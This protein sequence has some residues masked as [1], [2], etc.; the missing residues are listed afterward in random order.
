M[1]KAYRIIL[2]FALST[3]YCHITV[4]SE[5]FK[6]IPLGVRASLKRKFASHLKPFDGDGDR[7]AGKIVFIHWNGQKVS[8]LSFTFVQPDSIS[9]KSFLDD[10][11][12]Q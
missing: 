4:M 2:M 5:I 3:K 12:N 10:E 9:R 11:E 8:V 6:K 1:L 7:G